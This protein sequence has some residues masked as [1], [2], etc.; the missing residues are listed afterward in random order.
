MDLP[1]AAL[2]SPTWDSPGAFAACEVEPWAR[3]IS[4]LPL[5]A[6]VVCM[7]V[8]SGARDNV[9]HAKDAEVSMD[10]DMASSRATAMTRS[11]SSG[12][13]FLYALILFLVSKSIRHLLATQRIGCES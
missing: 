1:S 9:I 3:A 2:E 13:A 6:T 10:A 5:A 7:P 12:S 8:A 4:R 11:R